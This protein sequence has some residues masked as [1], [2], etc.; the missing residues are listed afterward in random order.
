M[1]ITCL[2][3]F[4]MQIFCGLKNGKIMVYDQNLWLKS[5]L[6]KHRKEVTGMINSGDLLVSVSKD[7]D[8]ITWSVKNKVLC[9]TFRIM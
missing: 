5:V 7:M 6:E 2:Q 9:F 4:Q 3:H 1:T 8:L